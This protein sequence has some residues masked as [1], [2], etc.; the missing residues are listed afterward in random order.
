ML[1]KEINITGSFT[2]HKL[3]VARA[4]AT[5]MNNDEY[6]VL[7]CDGEEV[8]SNV[9]GIIGVF[10][11]NQVEGTQGAQVPLDVLRQY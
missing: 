5:H 10:G 8:H 2:L 1:E 3:N 6:M 11:V 4:L 9:Q 7:T